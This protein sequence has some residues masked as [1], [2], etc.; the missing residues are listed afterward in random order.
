MSGVIRSD[1]FISLGG[2]LVGGVQGTVILTGAGTPVAGGKVQLLD[3]GTDDQVGIAS[4]DGSG[5]YIIPDIP[6]GT[7]DV[8]WHGPLTHCMAVGEPLQ[9]TVVIDGDF[10]VQD[11]EVQAVSANNRDNFQS[12][13]ND[14][15][16]TGCGS[17]SGP[18]GCYWDNNISPPDPGGHD[19]NVRLGASGFIGLGTDGPSSTKTMLYRW[20]A[21]P[22]CPGGDCANCN[23]TNG[24]APRLNPAGGF[25]DELWVSFYEKMSAD[26]VVGSDT[27]FGSSRE[28]KFHI[29]DMDRNASG[30]VWQ[31]WIEIG[32]NSASPA[33]PDNMRVRIKL[34]K[35]N[36]ST[37]VAETTSGDFGG[38]YQL[39]VGF[40]D[41]FHRWTFAILGI[42]DATQEFRFYLD[43]E[44]IRTLTGA[45]MN[46]VDWTQNANKIAFQMGAN[47]NNGPTTG[48]M[49]RSFREMVCCS[50]RPNLLNE[51]F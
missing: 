49:E 28:Y 46:G 2:S 12:Y 18:N 21:R 24:M 34:T 19:G 41:Q 43:G 38:D 48:G 44:L 14:V 36:G 33:N 13:G 50:G 32:D 39:G 17:T 20:P 27:C 22:S 3:E 47:I 51:I 8:R 9:Y 16:F 15:D 40:V 7:Y 11:I 30:D 42:H 37:V 6:D 45:W 35:N 4:V 26:F 31:F 10:V 23:Y 1:S 25:G 5:D 29:V